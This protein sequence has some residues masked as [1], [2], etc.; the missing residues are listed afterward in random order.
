MA[1]LL[2][3]VLF[4]AAQPLVWVR[5]LWRGRRQPEYREHIGERYGFYPPAPSAS[6][7]PRVES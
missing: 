4:Y 3:T 2:Y 5:L 1:R 7:H 6:E